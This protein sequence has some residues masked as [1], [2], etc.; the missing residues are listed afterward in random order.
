MTPNVPHD[1]CFTILRTH[2][3]QKSRLFDCFVVVLPTTGVTSCA[4]TVDDYLLQ[5]GFHPLAFVGWLDKNRK[6]TAQKEKQH[7]RQYKN[8]E[9][10]KQ[11]TKIQNTKRNKKQQNKLKNIKTQVE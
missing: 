3:S 6:D 10:T 4:V 8:T 7:T 2:S 9:Y 5:L 1:V 11:K